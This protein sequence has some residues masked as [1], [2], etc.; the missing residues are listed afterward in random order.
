MQKIILTITDNTKCHSFTA[1][2]RI[3]SVDKR[4]Q[5]NINEMKYKHEKLI[6]RK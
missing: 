2:K 4:E 1:I 3:Y 6:M 5:K